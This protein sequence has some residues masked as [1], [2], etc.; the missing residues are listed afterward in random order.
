MVLPTCYTSAPI[1]HWRYLDN[2]RPVWEKKLSDNQ[3][4]VDVQRHEA[5]KPYVCSECPKRFCTATE[6]RHHQPVHSE[7]RQFS[8]GWTLEALEDCCDEVGFALFCS[9]CHHLHCHRRFSTG[10][11]WIFV[12][13]VVLKVKLG[14]GCCQRDALPVTQ[15]TVSK[16]S[17]NCFIR[18]PVN[19]YITQFGAAFV[20]RF[21]RYIN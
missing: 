20:L 10:S 11:F 17:R 6:L 15:P 19:S 21:W 8:C 14:S 3:L 12:C 4:K 5:V 7:Y 9:Y 16:H 13:P 1:I 2:L 18:M